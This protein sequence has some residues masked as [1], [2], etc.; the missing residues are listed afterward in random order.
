M[1]GSNSRLLAVMLIAVASTLAR[2]QDAPADG[3]DAAARVLT[4]LRST[5]FTSLV[6]RPAPPILT[7]HD[8]RGP[9][10]IGFQQI[11][12]AAGIIF[13]GTVTAVAR[14]SPGEEAASTVVTF[15]VEHAVRGTAA[16]R[17]LIIREWAG[18][19][20]R[21]ERYRVGENVLLF[22]YPP[23]RLGLTSPVAGGWGRFEVDRQ[24]RVLMNSRVLI[25]SRNRA[26]FATGSVNASPEAV[27]LA[28]LTRAINEPEK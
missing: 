22:L 3:V 11:A 21:G 27:P 9:G 4:R 8:P 10:V 16:G 5:D 6:E 15:H 24:G 26:I 2:A 1:A 12:S 19:W 14:A 28:D 7:P 25:N 20:V 17:T 23:S 18:L 13:S